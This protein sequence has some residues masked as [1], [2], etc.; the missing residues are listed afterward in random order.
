M[1]VGALTETTS[2]QSALTL[3]TFTL[4][5][6]LNRL[7]SAAATAA[8]GPEL[9]GDRIAPLREVSFDDVALLGKTALSFSNC[10]TVAHNS[11]SSHH[12]ETGSSHF[13]KHLVTSCS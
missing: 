9:V 6:A 12:L 7:V 5:D 3:G 13:A 4:L 10:T 11:I 8:S 2:E 1:L